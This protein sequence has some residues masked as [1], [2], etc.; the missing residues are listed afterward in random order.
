MVDEYS[1]VSLTGVAEEQA[2]FTAMDDLVLIRDAQGYCQKVVTPHSRLLYQSADRLIGRSLQ[3][4]LPPLIAD[5]LLSGIHAALAQRQ[6]I[7]CEYALEIGDRTVWLDAR[8]SP[9]NDHLVMQ[10]V[11]DVTD[12]KQLE[13]KLAQ[14]QTQLQAILD[15]ASA[16]IVSFWFNQ[17]QGIWQYLYYSAGCEQIYGFT[18]AEL[19]ADNTLWRSRVHPDDWQQVILPNFDRLFTETQSQIEYRFLHT[20]N[21]WRW[22]GEA[23]TATWNAE[24]QCWWVITVAHDITDRKA[25]DQQLQRLNDELNRR[26][27]D[28]TQEVRQSEAQFRLF[29]DAAPLP[30][31]LADITTRR[32]VRVNTAYQKWLGYSPDELYTQTFLDV[33]HGEDVEADRLISEAMQRGT[34]QQA[35]FRKRFVKRSG[36]VVWA[37]LRVVRICDPQGRPQYSLSLSQDV[38]E[39][40]QLVAAREQAE[41]ALQQ[42]AAQD[43]LLRRLTQHIHQSLDLEEILAIAVAE[44]RHILGADR[45]LI[46][47]LQRDGTGIVRQES[48]IEGFPNTQADGLEQVILSDTCYDYFFQGCARIVQDIDQDPCTLRPATYLRAVGVQSKLTAPIIQIPEQGDRHLWGLLIVHAC[49]EA[50]VWQPEEADLLQQMANQLAIAIQ[51]A[52][53]Y[54]QAQLELAERQQ[55]EAHLRVLLQEKDVLLKE[56]HHRV[57]NNLQVISSLL[58]MQ[59]RLVDEP[60]AELLREA[61]NRVQSISIIHEHLYQSVDLSRIDFAEYVQILVNH[62]LRSYGADTQGIQVQLDIAAVNPGLNTAIPC[63][64]I[65]NELVSNSLK[66]AFSKTKV[67]KIKICLAS[68]PQHTTVGKNEGILIVQDNGVGFPPDVDWQS[69]HSL[70]LR[71]VCTLVDQLGGTI[72]LDRDRGTTFRITF[73]LTVP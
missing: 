17:T 38:T 39:A 45:A 21:T 34:L 31:S 56:V 9:I 55:A 51:Q 2:L 20:S 44:A 47:Q 13:F 71:I 46:F 26:V 35:E 15:R 64:L 14:S 22:I 4:N 29:F 42:Q 54:Q 10:V 50:R 24:A 58:R 48:V 41:A 36:E 40:M 61:Q 66:Y 3:E 32:F 67:G 5:Q 73:P 18:A 72:T 27:E 19:L 28:R 60:V 37:D 59:S 43:H 12:R 57:K 65:I 52:T 53:L 6:T 25:I 62:L 70:G 68:Q 69:S 16:A 63:G 49:A 1:D 30:L 7:H 23:A 33:T 11:R 8:L